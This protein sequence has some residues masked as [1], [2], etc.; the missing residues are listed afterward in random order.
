[1]KEPD[2]EL[3]ELTFSGKI[4]KDGHIE[5]LSNIHGTES[6]IDREEAVKIMAHLKIVYSIC[7]VE[8]NEPIDFDRLGSTSH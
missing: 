7:N 2:L 8:I 3:D 4:D 5:V 1:M 6:H